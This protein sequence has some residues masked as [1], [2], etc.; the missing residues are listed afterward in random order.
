MRIA[1]IGTKGLP[2]KWGGIERYVEEISR[3]LSKRG[4]QVTVFGSGWYMKDLHQST[5]EGIRVVSV[6][7]LHLQAVDALSNGAFAALGAMTGPY[8][9]VDFHGYGSYFFVPP[10]RA[11]GKITFVTSHGLIDGQWRNPKY[12]RFA[13]SMLRLAGRIGITQADHVVTVSSFWKNRIR[14]LFG[15]EADVLPSGIE[16]IEIR[17][18]DIIKKKYGLEGNDY[19]LFLGRIDPVKRVDWIIDMARFVQT[20]DRIVIA[21]GAQDSNTKRYLDELK[22]RADGRDQIVFTGPVVGRE[23]QELLSNCKCLLTP[24]GSEGLPIVLLEGMS[25][26][27][28]CIASDIE[29]HREVIQDRVNGFLFDSKDKGEF[30]KQVKY[31]LRLNRDQM[32]CMG[33]KARKSVSERYNW[34]QTARLTEEMFFRVLS[35]KR[36]RVIWK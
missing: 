12:G 34:D 16:A 15:R 26:G 14:D 29:A 13:H 17:K 35:K 21:G 9:I 1:M 5:Y 24:S 8:D 27:R 6:P 22:S 28:V 11:S 19:L 4:H 36:S 7:A 10:V 30:V 3:R 33:E 18:P 2:A 23:K 31:A 32:V 20:G 25:Y